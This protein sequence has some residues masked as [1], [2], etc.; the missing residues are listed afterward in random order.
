M[1]AVPVEQGRSYTVEVVG[2]KQV[3]GAEPGATEEKVL[4]TH[5]FAPPP[6]AERRYRKADPDWLRRVAER[7]EGNIE[8]QTITP[9]AAAG[10][11]TDVH[12]LWPWALLFAL[13]MLPLDAMLRR[14]ARAV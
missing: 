3:V 13:L 5:T 9:Q 4:A 8:P 11:T 12:R 6:S 1:A 7:T 2:D 14:P 10:V